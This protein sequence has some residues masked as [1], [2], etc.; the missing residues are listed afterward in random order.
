MNKR[1]IVIRQDDLP[2]PVILIDR[3]GR[4]RVM[5]IQSGNPEK[6]SAMMGRAHPLEAEQALKWLRNR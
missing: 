3:M 6:L 5:S 1:P 4:K 2:R